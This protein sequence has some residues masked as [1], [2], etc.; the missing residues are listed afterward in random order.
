MGNLTMVTVFTVHV[1]KHLLGACFAIGDRRYR[2][3]DVRSLGGDALVYAEREDTAAHEPARAG[4]RLPERT[5]FRY[6]D[7]AAFL[8]AAAHG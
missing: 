1:M 2:I 5:A 6:G 4:R 7:I 3:V 8:S